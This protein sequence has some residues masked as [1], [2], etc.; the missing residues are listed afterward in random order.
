MGKH[1][2]NMKK[3]TIKIGDE[4]IMN[5]KYRVADKYKNTVFTVRS[6]PFNICGTICVLLEDYSGGYAIDGL[7]KVER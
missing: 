2:G 3:E 6:E 1:G 4:V 5:E 7:T